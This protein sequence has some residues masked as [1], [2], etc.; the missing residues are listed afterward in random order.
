M[1]PLSAAE[2][3]SPAIHR[4]K[5]LL[6]QPFRRGRSWKLAATAYFCRLGTMFIPFPLLCLFLLPA[7][8]SAG[9]VAV[10]AL[11]VGV[12]VL[13]VIAILVFHLCSRLQFAFFDILLHRG[14]FVAPAWRKYGPQSLPWTGV[15]VVLGTA[16]TLI[17]ALRLAVYILPLLQLMH[18]LKPGQPP[19][20]EFVAAIF[21]GYGILLL[22]FGPLFL[23]S[24]LLGDFIVPSLALEDNGLAEAFRR[25]F[26]LIRR[27]PGQF[28]LYT[29][30]KL[31]LGLAV[32]MGAAIAWEMVFL[33]CTLLL[34]IIAGLF[35]FLLH[36]AGIPAAVLTALAI[37]VGIVWYLFVLV[38][39]LLLTLGTVHTFL[40]AYALYFLCGRYP[41][42]G[43][44][45]ERSEP[46][47]GVYAPPP[48]YLPQ[49][50]PPPPLEG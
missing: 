45:L 22:V 12:L 11:S 38:Y 49:Y 42:L 43:E 8:R 16:V 48:G 37:L 17:S 28:A 33:L 46:P 5:A 2:A 39:G 30:L 21:A 31:G 47:P 23:I 18:R 24:S 34:A 9:P 32:Y 10:S 35:G 6:F 29:L 14:E 20:P 27:E 26:E 15:K 19:P 44:L 50:P 1:R 13:T 25:M 36:L 41:L 7:A 40:D 4:T 3:I